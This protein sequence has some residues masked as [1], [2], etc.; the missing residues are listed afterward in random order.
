MKKI[1]FKEKMRIVRLYASSAC[2]QRDIDLLKSIKPKHPLIKRIGV[3][4]KDALFVLL[5][6]V[7]IDE[8]LSNRG[9]MAQVIQEKPIK[10]VRETKPKKDNITE[11]NPQS[12][13]KKQNKRRKSIQT[14]NG[15]S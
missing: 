2:I 14:S 10:P 3:S 12:G 15:R 9:K 8:I 1:D 7:T 13:K 5:D 6:F 11:S 4:N